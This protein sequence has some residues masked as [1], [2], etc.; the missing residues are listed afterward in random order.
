MG[1]SCPEVVVLDPPL[2][3][4]SCYAPSGRATG[5]VD[6]LERLF[7]VLDARRGE[8]DAVA[9]STGIDVPDAFHLDYYA[10]G[11]SMV[12]P[13]GGVEALLTHALSSL[14]GVPAAHSPM[15][16]SREIAALDP[17]V[18]DPR[19]AAEVISI[20]FFVSVL[21]GLHA[22]PRIVPAIGGSRPGLVAAED[23]SCL[24]LPEG[25]LG[26]PTLAALEQGIPVIAV[27]ENAS[28]SEND[29]EALPWARGRL[30]VVD[31]YWEAAGVVAALRA[32]VAPESVRRPL[33]RTVVARERTRATAGTR[34][35]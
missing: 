22:S 16:G 29:L 8:F 31:N 17:G 28:L 12:N 10:A 19:M 32:G 14:Y 18:V 24:V 23:V 25:A 33:R 34:T 27:R 13:W 21:K 15:F 7:S 20:G 6:E 4:R 1:V 5:A 2:P 9:L 35:R 30:W 3:V 26:L 11:G